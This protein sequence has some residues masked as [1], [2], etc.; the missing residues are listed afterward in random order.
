MLMMLKQ[1][2][3]MLGVGEGRAE[4]VVAGVAQPRRLA[5]GDGAGKHAK[6]ISTNLTYDVKRVLNPVA[7]VGLL[8]VGFADRRGVAWAQGVGLPRGT[9]GHAP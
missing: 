9:G 5:G 8:V 4:P 6:W 3:W 2:L 7:L 1:V